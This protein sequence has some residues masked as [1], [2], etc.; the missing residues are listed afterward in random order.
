MNQDSPRPPVETCLRCN[1]EMAW[2][3][4][5]WQCPRCRFKI[6]C[7]E[8]ATDDCAPDLRTADQAFATR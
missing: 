2:R 3:H 7:C 5:S 8:G 6:G 4:A 1:A